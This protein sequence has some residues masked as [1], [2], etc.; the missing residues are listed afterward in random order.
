MQVYIKMV[1]KDG[2]EKKVFAERACF[3]KSDDCDVAKEDLI[4][5]YVVILSKALD[6]VS[7]EYKEEI[8]A[9]LISYNQDTRYEEP[10]SK[11]A[12]CWNAIL[13]AAEKYNAA[14]T[15]E[16]AEVNRRAKEA[17]EAEE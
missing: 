5:N 13:D 6:T 14:Q 12:R 3:S 17:E 10:S 1:E 11:L 7:E 2:Y 15:E 4:A 9:D 8:L 16:R